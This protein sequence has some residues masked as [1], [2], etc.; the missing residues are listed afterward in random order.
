MTTPVHLRALLQSGVALPPLAGIVS[1]TAPLPRE[2]AA[3][4]EARWHTELR[5]VFGFMLRLPAFR[6]MSA[7]AALHAFY[8]YGAAAF[9]PIF[10]IRVHQMSLVEVGAWLDFGK[11]GQAGTL[12]MAKVDPDG[13]FSSDYEDLAFARV[14]DCD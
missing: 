8:G 12:A 9:I 3:E 11:G 10:L 14:R 1:A 4:A 7:G 5:E 6:H 2:L 13:D